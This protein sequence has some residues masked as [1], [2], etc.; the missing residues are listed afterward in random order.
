MLAVSSLFAQRVVKEARFAVDY[1]EP[2]RRLATAE[3]VRAVGLIAAGHVHVSIRGSLDG[4]AW[5]PWQKVLLGHE[6]GTIVWFEQGVR[7]IETQ[8]ATGLHV[9]LIEPGRSSERVESESIVSRAGWGCGPECNPVSPPVYAPVTHL[10]V[11]HSAGGNTASD[12]AAVV[13]SIWVLH[14]RGNGW[15][16]IGYNYLID[17]NGLIYEGRAG[18]DGV[19]GAHFSGVNTGTMGVC[20]MGTYS[21]VAPTAAALQSLSRLLTQQASRWSLDPLGQ[22][23][24]TASGLTLNVISGHRDAG[25]SSRASGTTECPG[26]GLYTW[27]PSLR[28]QLERAR[29]C[30]PALA[31]RNYCFGASGGSVPV[32]LEVHPG[33]QIGVSGGAEWL[34][35][36]DGR[37]FADPNTASSRRAA[38]LLIGGSVVQVAQAESG[39][40]QMP[41]IARGGVVN[42][43]S[44]DSRPL[45]LGS[46]ASL[47]GEDL[48]REG[49]PAIV[50]VNG[51]E[52]AV[53]GALP[54]QIN[55]ALPAGTQTG[56]ARL[57]VVRQGIRSPETMIWV[58]EAAPAIFAAQ[59]FDDDNLHSAANPV[60]PGRPLILY[61]TGIGIDR[62]LP[63][64]AR[65]DGASAQGLFLGPAPGFIGLGQANVA[66]PTNLNPGEHRLEIIVSGAASPA[67]AL[68]AASV[69]AN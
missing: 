12:W 7:Q 49:A 42:A 3:P 34:R 45:A 36:R 62:T 25:L 41:C 16:D 55:F 22:T 20:L 1:D 27:L 69:N 19:V 4:A 54:G 51:R 58:T 61:L 2:V 32:P 35:V 10:V 67:I 59:N 28:D 9:L 56:S 6:G 38:D 47:F 21:T 13:R 57:Q 24:H 43:A 15:N 18:G 66:V 64:E 68:F 33:C 39:V 44:F 53:F 52:A 40:E 23:L 5:T 63:W 29:A 46:I 30:A 50:T 37:L 31:R 65:V 11:H 60:R 17:P 26:N 14:V 8:S 48:W